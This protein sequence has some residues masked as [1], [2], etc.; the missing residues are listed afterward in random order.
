MS[1]ALQ[2]Y[3]GQL[4]LTAVLGTPLTPEKVYQTLLDLQVTPQGIPDIIPGVRVTQARVTFGSDI[5]L[6]RLRALQEDLA[7]R[8]H[9]HSATL[10]PVQGG[11]VFELA[12][13]PV[14]GS[15]VS[16]GDVL[17]G[18]DLALPDMQLP[19]AVGLAMDGT[20]I[21]RDLADAP[22]VLIGGVTGSGKS[23]F[24]QSMVLSLAL[25][26]T[27]QELEL[28]FVDPKQVDLAELEAL[29]H[30][31]RPICT[32]P[33]DVQALLVT[34]E[35]EVAFR[36][37]EFNLAGVQDLAGYNAWATATEGEETMPRIVVVID[38]LA[39]LLSNDTDDAMATSL[40]RLAQVSRAAGI[41]LVAATQRPSAQVLPTQLRSQFAT[42]LSCRVATAADSRLVLD[43]TGAEKLAGMGDALLKWGGGETLRVQGVYINAS[44]R[45]WLREAIQ[46]HYYV[47]PIPKTPKPR[48]TKK[49]EDSPREDAVR[50][51]SPIATASKPWWRFW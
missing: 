4:E 23:A 45:K 18:A 14:E 6:R 33:E 9:V 10:R 34:L 36:Y 16:L 41:H 51:T 37:E 28:V 8:L 20:P 13:D 17:A 29:P 49:V 47:P 43:E 40:T 21:I 46:F 44:W 15:V 30:L 38:E 11:V 1:S 48:K 31:K 50:V 7:H 12:H 27:P 39:F 19:W 3:G 22:H 26:R 5:L 24:L 2:Q 42:R 25:A 35:S 32:T